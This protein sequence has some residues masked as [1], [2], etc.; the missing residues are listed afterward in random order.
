MQYRHPFTQFEDNVK[1]KMSIRLATT[2]LG[3]LVKSQGEATFTLVAH[4]YSP[5]TSCHG[6]AKH[7]KTPLAMAKHAISK[8]TT[9]KFRVGSDIAQGWYDAIGTFAQ[10]RSS[11]R[12]EFDSTTTTDTSWTTTQPKTNTGHE[13]EDGNDD[14]A[15][16]NEATSSISK[17]VRHD[18]EIFVDAE[19]HNHHTI[20]DRQLACITHNPW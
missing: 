2:V 15:T 13:H 20:A 8:L 16:D 11:A 10:K 7:V 9:L 17:H 19:E 18:N 5:Q 6:P 14:S 12:R 3:D 4:N 1:P